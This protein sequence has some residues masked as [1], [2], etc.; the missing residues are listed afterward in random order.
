MTGLK[1]DSHNANKGTDRGR[2]LLKHSL[3][4][5]GAGRSILADKNGNIIAGNK[6]FEQ[7]SALGLKMREIETNGDEL[8]V[9]KRNDLDLYDGNKARELAYADNRVAELIC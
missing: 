9:V 5:L 6:T 4:E 1:Q 3:Q 7:A 8:V 2:E